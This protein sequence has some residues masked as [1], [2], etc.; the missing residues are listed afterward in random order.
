MSGFPWLTILIVLPL[1]GAAIIFAVKDSSVRPVTLGITVTDLLISLPLL[2]A[3][4][5]RLAECYFLFG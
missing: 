3:L 1:I 5:T 4:F 2:S